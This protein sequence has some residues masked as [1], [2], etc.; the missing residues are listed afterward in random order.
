MTLLS[1]LRYYRGVL[2]DSG[3]EHCKCATAQNGQGG[4]GELSSVR[5]LLYTSPHSSGL[6]PR[7]VSSRWI[8]E[9]ERIVTNDHLYD[10]DNDTRLGSAYGLAARREFVDK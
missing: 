7:R 2:D 1:P 5:H 8:N 6:I 9:G 10:D 3:T 4:R